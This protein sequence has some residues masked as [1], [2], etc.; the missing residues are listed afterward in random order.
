MSIIEVR[1]TKKM[2]QDAKK[3]GKALGKLKNSHTGGASNYIGML[4]E[5]IV[6]RVTGGLLC[7][8]R[9]YDVMANGKKLEVKTKKTKDRSPPR[10]HFECSVAASNTRQKCDAYVFV[11]VSTTSNKAWICGMKEK[12]D[13]YKKAHFCRKGEKDGNYTHVA[14]SYNIAIKQLSKLK[15]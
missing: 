1:Y 9:D 2:L 3:R 7:D 15:T 4:G 12:K 11:R 10:P 5:D 8:R 6:R 14:D 13:F